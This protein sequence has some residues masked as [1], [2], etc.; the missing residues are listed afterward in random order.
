[1]LELVVVDLRVLELHIEIYKKN[2]AS[3][4]RC[5]KF[6]ALNEAMIE[7]IKQ[8]TGT[9]YSSSSEVVFQLS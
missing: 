3:Y 6:L 5:L 8:I 4:T 1:M 7:E 2:V 9:W